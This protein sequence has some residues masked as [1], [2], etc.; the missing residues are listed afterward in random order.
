MD[1]E[2]SPWPSRKAASV[3]AFTGP[4]TSSLR[5]TPANTA[6]AARISAV[7]SSLR[8][9]RPADVSIAV[10]GRCASMSAIASP[11]EANTGT[12]DAYTPCASMRCTAE[13]PSASAAE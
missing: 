10:V 11:V 5:I 1:V 2:K 3:R 6:S 7:T 8:I 4:A 13:R 9:R 12:L